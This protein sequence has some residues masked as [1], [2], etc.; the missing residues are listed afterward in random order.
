M[1]I[2]FELR[3]DVRFSNS[4]SCTSSTLCEGLLFYN[5]CCC[6]CTHQVRNTKIAVL[7]TWY[8]SISSSSSPRLHH[9]SYICGHWYDIVCEREQR[10]KRPTSNF[11]PRRLGCNRSTFVLLLLL[12][13]CCTPNAPAAFWKCCCCEQLPASSFP[14]TLLLYQ[15]RVLVPRNWW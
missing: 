4:H 11:P 15:N 1:T 2:W 10:A 7:P 3:P 13:P 9:S 14:P 8:T 5:N 12:L 6:T